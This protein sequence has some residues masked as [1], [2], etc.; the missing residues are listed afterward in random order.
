M[1]VT[2]DE[3]MGALSRLTLPDG[4]DL[5]SRDMIRALGVDGGTVRFVIEAPDAS[6]AAR[7]E[8]QRK[9]AE[10]RDCCA[11][12]GDVCFCCADRARPCCTKACAAEP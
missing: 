8:P 2:R 5:V 1:A 9:A 4:G 6:M 11:G 3:I 10:T 7:M 12:R